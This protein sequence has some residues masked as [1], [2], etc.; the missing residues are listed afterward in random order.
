M[1]T[2]KGR[3]VYERVKHPFSE[4]DVARILRGALEDLSPGE[5]GEYLSR[6]LDPIYKAWFPNFYLIAKFVT[7]MIRG[8]YASWYISEEFVIYVL[9]LM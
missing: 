2:Q 1:I 5:A 3:V 6:I 7:A 8:W 4:K 9:D